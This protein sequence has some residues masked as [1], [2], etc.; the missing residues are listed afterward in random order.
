VLAVGNAAVAINNHGVVV[1]TSAS[2]G[3][4]VN[5]PFI[6]TKAKGIEHL[7]LLPG[8]VVGAG[9]AINN[10]GEV[11]GASISP[12]GPATG[13]PSAVLWRGGADG[14]VT[15]LNSFLTAES[16]FAALL[17][18]FGIND[19]GEIVGFGVTS[20]GDIHGFR[21]TPAHNVGTNSAEAAPPVVRRAV[22]LSESARR[23]IGGRLV[24]NK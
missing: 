20:S 15:D 13:N 9:L 1:G 23:L 12:G 8:D 16:P 24:I 6:W 21:A 11:V 3:N 17:T 10:R 2:P 5:Q 19:A 18:A 14:G 4:Q 7:A 22:A